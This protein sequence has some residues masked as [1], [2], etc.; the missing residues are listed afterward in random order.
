[1]SC[2]LVGAH[3]GNGKKPTVRLGRSDPRALD[4]PSSAISRN[5]I[6]G[7]DA[8]KGS[9]EEVENED[10]EAKRFKLRRQDGCMRM[11]MDEQEFVIRE[12]HIDNDVKDVE[13]R[14]SFLAR[15][16]NELMKQ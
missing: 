7:G 3:E 4:P 5:P 9:P 6:R 10:G 13:S 12:P 16:W 2:G 8:Q 1:M 11:I 15:R 14:S